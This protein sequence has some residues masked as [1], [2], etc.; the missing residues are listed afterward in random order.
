LNKAKWLELYGVDMH[1][2]QGKD[3]NQYRLG[4]TPTGMLVFD[5]NQKIGL[6]FWPKIQKLSFKNRKL[7]LVVEEDED[8]QVVVTTEIAQKTNNELQNNGQVQLHTF[9]FHLTSHKA[10][11]HL[12]KCAIEHHSFFRLTSHHA[13]RHARGQLFRLGSTFRYR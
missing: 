4:L 9:V 3:S 2:V 10:S 1:V 6:F 8:P 13:Q 11:K 7:T 5:G 12:W